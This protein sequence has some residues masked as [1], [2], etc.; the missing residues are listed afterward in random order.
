MEG[1]ERETKPPIEISGYATGGLTQ[2]CRFSGLKISKQKFLKSD[3]IRQH[4][5]TLSMRLRAISIFVVFAV[6]DVQVLK[7]CR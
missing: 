6:F 1:E 7:C 3:I 4:I 5:N 2:V